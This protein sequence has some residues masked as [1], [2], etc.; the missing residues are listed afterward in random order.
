MAQVLLIPTAI[1]KP[2]HQQRTKLDGRE[3]LLRFSWN[4][5]EARWYLT[6]ADSENTVL[7]AGI[8]LICN[9]PL[10]S[11]ETEYDERLPLGELEVTD[12][13]NAGAGDPPG[14]DELGEGKRCELTYFAVTD[15]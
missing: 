1:A 4:Q 5:R 8:K 9:W 15:Q 7:R 2:Y 10:L 12:L 13:T 14:F 6:I 3:F 11:N